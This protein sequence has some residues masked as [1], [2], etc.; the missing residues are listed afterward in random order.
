MDMYSPAVQQLVAALMKRLRPGSKGPMPQPQQVPQ[1]M[2]LSAMP[3]DARSLQ[4]RKEE[5]LRQAME[6][7]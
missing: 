3:E 1:Y 7:R 5:I 4:L 6:G 2:P